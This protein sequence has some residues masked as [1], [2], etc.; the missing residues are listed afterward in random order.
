MISHCL[1]QV[2]IGAIT[3][4]GTAEGRGSS[5]VEYSVVAKIV[6]GWIVTLPIAGCVA[7]AIY[8]ALR[9]THAAGGDAAGWDPA[10]YACSGKAS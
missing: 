9:A 3:G 2:L 5:S 7:A 8:T 4:V 6:A 1:H 10:A